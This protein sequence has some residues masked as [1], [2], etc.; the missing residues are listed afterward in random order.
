[1]VLLA[2]SVW[3][4]RS[5]SRTLSIFQQASL[6]AVGG[7]LVNGVGGGV[8][9]T[10]VVGTGGVVAGV[11]D[12]TDDGVGYGGVADAFVAGVNRVVGGFGVARGMVVVVGRG[13]GVAATRA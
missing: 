12:G 1:M 3:M 9:V 7:N 2:G 8:H 4:L 11:V 13:Q 5:S 10:T 6:I